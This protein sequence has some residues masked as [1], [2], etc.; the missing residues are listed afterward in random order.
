MLQIAGLHH[1]GILSQVG[2]HVFRVVPF[3]KRIH[4][5]ADELSV[6]QKRFGAVF[7]GVGS[8]VHGRQ[9]QHDTQL[10]A[11]ALGPQG[12]Y[13]QAVAQQQ[14]VRC[15][16][17]CA[18]ALD[19]GGEHA[20]FMAQHGHHP[21][22]VV[23]DYRC[24]PI[25]QSRVDAFGVFHKAVYRIAVGPATQG[26]QRVRQVPMVQCEIRLDTPFQ[27]AIDQPVVKSQ[28]LFIPGPVTGRTHARP[29][30]GEAVGIHAQPS[31]HVQIVGPAMVVFAGDVA[32]AAV[33]NGT[34]LPAEAVPDR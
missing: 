21:G 9:V 20:G 29:R 31:N 3:E 7:G 6:L 26:L 33:C 27:H 25:T 23:G 2:D 17:G 32:M 22:F 15:L 24:E 4:V 13:G 10:S 12:L 1:G 19:A 16:R 5:P 30:H 8:R 14:M 18:A 34:R 28:A 11:A